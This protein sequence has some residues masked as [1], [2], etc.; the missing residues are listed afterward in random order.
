MY[1]PEHFKRIFMHTT[2][3][4]LQ[5]E[6]HFFSIDFY[7][8][9]IPRYCLFAEWIYVNISVEKEFE[10]QDNV[11]LCCRKLGGISAFDLEN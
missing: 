6:I 5:T 11:M 2:G 1:L 3:E 8:L 9:V 10:R 4:N 7:L